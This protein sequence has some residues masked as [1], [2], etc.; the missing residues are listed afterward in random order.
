MAEYT[1]III[2]LHLDKGTFLG[3]HSTHFQG[4][5]FLSSLQHI[6]NHDVRSRG[7]ISSTMRTPSIDCNTSLDARLWSTSRTGGRPLL[8]ITEI[9]Q[10]T[11]TLRVLQRYRSPRTLCGQPVLWTY[12]GLL[13][14]KPCWNWH[15][16][17]WT[18][19]GPRREIVF[20]PS[21][22]STFP[23]RLSPS[24]RNRM[25]MQDKI[26]FLQNDMVHIRP[27]VKIAG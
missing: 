16:T 18:P 27:V 20:G 3:V 25:K 10:E 22:C 14:E 5:P 24:S 12:S 8:T 23:G 1:Y 17:A 4:Q 19:C 6:Y 2:Y 21:N 26:R 9:I 11:T 7:F 15:H 13:H